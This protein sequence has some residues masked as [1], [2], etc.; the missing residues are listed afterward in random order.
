MAK[1][2]QIKGRKILD[3]RGD[4]TIEVDVFLDDG[5][6]GRSSVPSGASTGR[7]EA[8]K[9]VDIDQV[10]TNVKN[11]STALNGVEATDQQKIDLLMIN[12]DGT[13][14]KQKLGGNTIL[15]ISLAVCD[16]A[17]KSLKMPL[18]RYIGKISGLSDSSYSM[19]IPMFNIINGGKHA[20]NNLPFQEF[21]I[22]PM[23]AK[24]IH[25]RINEG[26]KVFKELKSMMKKM[27]LSTNV[28]DEGGFAPKLNS[29][30]EAL[31]LLKM[32]IINAGFTPKV[33]IGIGID[34][35]ASSI[36]DLSPITYPLSSVE[37][38]KKLIT[39]YPIILLE[40]GLSED[41]WDEWIKL[42]QS[43][44]NEICVVGDDLFTTNSQRL[45]LGIER[46]AA[47]GIIIKPDQIGTLSETIK[48]IK[49]AKQAGYATIISHRSGETESTFIADL[50]VGVGADFI[51]TGAPDRGE[52]VAKYNQL[53]RIEEELMQ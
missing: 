16:A 25:Q 42:T 48:T 2:T 15:A 17:A 14:N 38:Y 52:R 1:I 44:G 32:A 35:A 33:D 12:T 39:K 34:V 9:I 4:Y 29:N 49:L 45:Q 28:G 10:I 6:M 7:Y 43:I 19:P 37:Y 46:K 8:F 23:G 21:M 41:D 27:G 53:L 13:G 5:T 40:D 3:S 24:T 22:I 26:D 51:K 36:N 18:Y 47:N 20:D 11:L 31:E 30:E 50:A